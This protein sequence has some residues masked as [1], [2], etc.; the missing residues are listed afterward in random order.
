MADKQ[1]LPS[2]KRF[3]Q[4]VRV[5]S[6]YGFGH[7][8]H[9]KMKSEKMK[10]DPE[11]LR[12]VFEELGPTFIKIGQI[13]STRP[14]V[15][16]AEYIA[17]L[18]KLQDKVP[19]FSSATVRRIIEE[20]L[21]RPT[22]EIFLS[23]E[24]DPIACASVAQV[25]R[26]VLQNGTPV[27]VKVQRPD[28]EKSLLE[29]IDILLRIVK[30]APNTLRDVLLD[31]V[32]ALEEI[33]E[34]TKVELDFTNEVRFVQRFQKENKDIACIMTPQVILPL[35][36]ARVV[37]QEEI[38]GI[39]ISDK[40]ALLEEGY[41]LE[42]IGRKLVLSFL[43]Q[44][45]H[46]G[47]FHGDPHPGNLIIS[48]R[49]IC[50]IDF[51]IMGSLS[52]KARSAINDLLLSLVRKDI[53]HLVN[54]VLDVAV[55]KGPVNKNLLYEDLE[56]IIHSYLQTSLKHIQVSRLFMDLFEAARKNNLK[57]PREY[58]T[59]LKALLILEGVISDL[60][61]EIS[62]LEIARDYL[63]EDKALA[64]RPEI[65]L[66]QLLLS[67]YTLL[68]DS[69]RIPVSLSTILDNFISG[70]GKVKLDI[71]NF[72]HRWKDFNKMVNRVVF[73]LVVSAIIIASALIIRSGGGPEINGV[74]V[75]GL[76]GF[77][78]AGFLGLWLLFSIL[79]SGN[80]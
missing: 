75:V 42:D 80:I 66:D 78:L 9:A 10:N 59:L 4:I 27:I 76:L 36:T 28:I 11:N 17:E 57:L 79:K 2:K 22:G 3:R 40:A 61:P 63:K 33:L 32:E 70:R 30:R 1:S 14:D 16:P 60:A 8:L 23:L 25:H 58:T 44:L 51:G 62:I 29:D 53:G 24:E 52:P 48:E 20:E 68:Q 19:P 49:K 35:S 7:I 69:L 43:Y 37:V 15:L 56:N 54:L 31:P 26:A 13:L 65:S 74:S 47:F 77:G 73:A 71:I 21:H 12:L 67:G 38:R 64:F 41:D 34:T 39:K 6:S 45:F 5:L 72:D 55:Q 46:N 50:Y 18:S